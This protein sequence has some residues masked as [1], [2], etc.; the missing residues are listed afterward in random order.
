MKVSLDTLP[1]FHSTV[2]CLKDPPI[3]KSPYTLEAT[4]E[5][6]QGRVTTRGD[7]ISGL[8]N[9]MQPR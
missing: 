3:P 4:E 1:A 9:M 5:L 6:R 7:V 8:S 2:F